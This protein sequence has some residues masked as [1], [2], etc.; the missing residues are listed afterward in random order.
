MKAIELITALVVIVVAVEV[1]GIN[2]C[3][4]RYTVTICLNKSDTSA[5]LGCLLGV[6]ANKR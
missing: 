4:P 3:M 2:E 6:A 5:I 1:E